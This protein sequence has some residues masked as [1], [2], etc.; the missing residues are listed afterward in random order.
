VGTY[1][2]KSE[3]IVYAFETWAATRMVMVLFVYDIQEPRRSFSQHS[4]DK[5]IGVMLL[6]VSTADSSLP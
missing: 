2:L 5:D 4:P 1:G 6:F 3:T